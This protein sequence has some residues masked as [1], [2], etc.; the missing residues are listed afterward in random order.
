MRTK[1]FQLVR[2]GSIFLGCGVLLML[3]ACTA[4]RATLT[5]AGKYAGAAVSDTNPDGDSLVEGLEIR[6]KAGQFALTG[7]MNATNR[8]EGMEHTSNS[9]WSWSGTG[10]VVGDVLKFTYSSTLE[11]RGSG[12]LRHGRDGLLLRL[13]DGEYRLHRAPR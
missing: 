12:S 4:G 6:E 9:R 5:F 8:E 13:D 7:Y 2:T 1:I 3:P 10:A 11:E